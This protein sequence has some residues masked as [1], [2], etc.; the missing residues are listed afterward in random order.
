MHKSHQDSI[1]ELAKREGILRPRDLNPYQIPRIYLN[2][3]TKQGLLRQVGRGLYMLANA[4]PTEHH[5]LT[6]ACK[7][8]PQGVVCLLSAL[9]FH[10]LTTQLPHEVWMA[11]PGTTRQPKVDQ[12]AM[13]FHRFSGPALT[14]GIDTQNIEGVQVRVYNPA[15]TVADC[16]KY[17]NK[18]GLDI[19]IEALKDYIYQRKETPDALWH[20]AKTCRMTRVMQPYIEAIL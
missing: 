17:R 3:L 7:R 11:I 9:R 1:L 4:E 18:I 6:E 2:R 10:G 19:A 15:K 14:E 16:F 20:Y 13:R 12:P 8:V 5:A